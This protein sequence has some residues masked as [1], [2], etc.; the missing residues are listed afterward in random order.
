MSLKEFRLGLKQ[1]INRESTAWIAIFSQST[2]AL[3][4]GS[5]NAYRVESDLKC[6]IATYKMYIYGHQSQGFIASLH[7]SHYKHGHSRCLLPTQSK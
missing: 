5:V 2:V 4:E 7:P 3:Y 6:T 1:G